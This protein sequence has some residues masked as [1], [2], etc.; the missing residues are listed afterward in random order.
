M[1]ILRYL[2]LQ[3]QSERKLYL[4]LGCDRN[5]SEYAR[6]EFLQHLRSSEMLCCVNWQV[7]TKISGDHIPSSSIL[8]ADN[9]MNIEIAERIEKGNKTYF[10]N[11]KL[12]K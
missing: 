7:A 10:A 11:A 3:L 6:Y 1:F 5:K 12:M 8:N 9:K 4:A 2:A